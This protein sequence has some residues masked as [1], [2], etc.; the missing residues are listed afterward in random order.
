MNMLSL[1][2]SHPNLGLMYSYCL[3]RALG[4]L[5]SQPLRILNHANCLDLVSNYKTCC[6]PRL[7][8][9]CHALPSLNQYTHLLQP[10]RRDSSLLSDSLC[11]FSASVGWLRVWH[12]WA[13]RTV[14]A[15]SGGFSRGWE[16]PER[17][18][19]R[20]RG[21]GVERRWKEVLPSA[22]QL[23]KCGHLSPW[24]RAQDMLVGKILYSV[25][26]C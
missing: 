23:K 6:L 15:S 1:S 7:F 22:K 21:G 25:G 14:W 10:W 12:Q 11:T 5:Q 9:T 18:G 3:C 13:D 2:I 19:G 8:V 4:L 24:A 26:Y 16:R 17:R 20:E